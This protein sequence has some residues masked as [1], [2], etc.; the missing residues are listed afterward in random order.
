[1]ER[2]RI[3]FARGVV[4]E[5][6]G[7]DVAEAAINVGRKVSSEFYTYM[8]R[9]ITAVPL[10]KRRRWVRNSSVSSAVGSDPVIPRSR[11]EKKAVGKRM[12]ITLSDRVSSSAVRR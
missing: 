6:P 3:V 4:Q 11:A 2:E 1:M 8:T 9:R 12:L 10:L 5:D 7:A